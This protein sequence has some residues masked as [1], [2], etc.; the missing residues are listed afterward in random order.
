M[1]DKILMC[2]LLKYVDT[3][4]FYSRYT[5]LLTIQTAHID[6]VKNS[7]D[8][9]PFLRLLTCADIFASLIFAVIDG[10]FKHNCEKKRTKHHL[11]CMLAISFSTSE[12]R[13]SL[14]A[15]VI[16]ISHVKTSFEYV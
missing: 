12:P 1:D 5:F 7:N 6:E 3:V 14:H 16:E 8:F 2:I 15:I 13:N 4:V 9:F 10:Y 11:E